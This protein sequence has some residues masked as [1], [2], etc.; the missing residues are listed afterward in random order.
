MYSSYHSHCFLCKLSSAPPGTFSGTSPKLRADKSRSDTV[1]SDGDDNDDDSES[2]GKFH[3]FLGTHGCFRADL[4]DR[5]G[6]RPNSNPGLSRN[7]VWFNRPECEASF[8]LAPRNGELS[9]FEPKT[10]ERSSCS[11]SSQ[12]LGSVGQ[13]LGSR[14]IYTQR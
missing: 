6:F 8:G 12:N 3:T 4:P 5:T 7:T 11:D 2:Q 13:N 1:A 9:P 10:P 14:G